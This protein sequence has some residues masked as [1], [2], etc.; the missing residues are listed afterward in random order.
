MVYRVYVE[1]KESLRHEAAALLGE[2]RTLLAIT[3]LG[4][5]TAFLALALIFFWCIDKRRGYLLMAV[6][7]AGTILNQFMKLWFRVPRPWVLDENFTILER[8]QNYLLQLK[9]FKIG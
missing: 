7:F 4:E 8:L 5:E 9:L 1:K 6:G 3:T 2:I